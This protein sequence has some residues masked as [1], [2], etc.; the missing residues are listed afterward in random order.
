M[1]YWT[2]RGSFSFTSQRGSLFREFKWLTWRRLF[3][4]FRRSSM[5]G[6]PKFSV[7]NVDLVFLYLRELS[8]RL[9]SWPF[10]CD[11]QGRRTRAPGEWRSPWSFLRHLFR[12]LSTAQKHSSAHWAQRRGFYRFA[13]CNLSDCPKGLGWSEMLPTLLALSRLFCSVHCPKQSVQWKFGER[14]L[15]VYVWLL[16]M[17]ET[18]KPV[19]VCFSSHFRARRLSFSSMTGFLL[20]LANA[21]DGDKLAMLNKEKSRN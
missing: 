19:E 5:N 8:W 2:C 20:S 10:F 4:C 7:L 6:I 21:A 18:T 15:T 3:F 12:S 13:K 17:T 16:I 14:C 9:D 1:V 11:G